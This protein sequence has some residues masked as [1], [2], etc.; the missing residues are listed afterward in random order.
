MGNYIIQRKLSQIGTPTSIKRVKRTPCSVPCPTGLLRIYHADD[1]AHLC[2]PFDQCSFADT[3]S[4]AA[5]S[6][7]I[8]GAT[9]LQELFHAARKVPPRQHHATTTRAANQ[10]DIC[11]NTHDFPCLAA[12]RMRFA[13]LHNVAHIELG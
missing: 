2:A 9:A 13:H 3:R 12:T 11:P 8:S 6:D 5:G 4:S 1:A 7:F 10:P